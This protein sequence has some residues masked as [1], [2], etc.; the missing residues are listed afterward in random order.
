MTLVQSRDLISGCAYM[1]TVSTSA[2]VMP[3]MIIALNILTY[4]AYCLCR[5]QVSETLSQWLACSVF[6][7]GSFLSS[8][9]QV[10]YFHL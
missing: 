2:V 9:V 10:V 1:Q 7:Y 5:L 3:R 8:A 6:N 4:A